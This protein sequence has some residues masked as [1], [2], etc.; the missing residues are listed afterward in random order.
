MLGESFFEAGPLSLTHIQNTGSAFG[1][2]A[3]QT[4]LLTI[5]AIA[6]L[7][8]ILLFYR[9]I[10]QSNIWGTLALSL[11][12]SGALGNL[13]DRLRFG[14]VTDF[15]YVRLWHNFYWPAFNVADSAITIG[16]IALIFF[17]FTGLKKEHDH[18]S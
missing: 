10:P 3:N 7:V 17:I 14:Y 18:P 6:G 1:L 2:F 11:V 13:I 15:I 9:Q 4:F 5:V 12:F 8:I 16:T